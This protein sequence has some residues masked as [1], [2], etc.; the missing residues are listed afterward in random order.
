MAFIAYLF[1]EIQDKDEITIAKIYTI[2]IFDKHRNN[3][4]FQSKSQKQS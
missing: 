4:Y 3:L 2:L 1:A